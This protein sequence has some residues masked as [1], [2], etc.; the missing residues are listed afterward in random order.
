MGKVIYVVLELVN[1]SGHHVSRVDSKVS[2]SCVSHFPG[3]L[4]AEPTKSHLGNAQ[5]GA[6]W[7]KGKH[8][9][10]GPEK[11]RM[12][13]VLSTSHV[14]SFLVNGCHKN[15]ISAHASF[16][17]HKGLDQTHG[18]RDP[19]FHVAGSAAVDQIIFDFRSKRWHAPAFADWNRV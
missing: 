11:T 9:V 8:L 14:R 1:N 15:Q 2:S 6:G 17:L 19:A 3:H 10:I 18:N 7:L 4:Y 16:S 5:S 13:Q 12:N